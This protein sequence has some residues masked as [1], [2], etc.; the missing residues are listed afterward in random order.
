[1]DI[2]KE[3]LD[4]LNAVLKVKVT[5]NDYKAQVDSALKNYTKKASM[6]G[7]RPGKVPSA[8]VKKM[9]GKSILVDEINKMLN[10]NIHKYIAD[11][12]IEILGNPIP[13]IDSESSIDWDKQS[14]FEFLFDLGLAPQLKIDFSLTD[15][16]PYYNIIVD[17]A[18]IDKYVDDV[19]KRYGKIVPQEVSEADD[20][21]YGDLVELDASNEILAGGIFRTSSIFLERYNKNEASKP[22]IGVKQDEKVIVDI[23]KLADGPADCAAMLGITP[24]AAEKITSKFQFAVKSISRIQ[25][26]EIN[27]ELFEKIYGKDQVKTIDDFRGRIK[28]ELESH[29]GKESERR[30]FTDTVA[31]IKKNVMV[32]LPDEFLKRWIIATNEKPITYEQVSAEYDRYADPLKWQLIEN[33][34][35]KDNEITVTDDEAADYLRNLIRNQYKRYNLNDIEAGELEN[36]A[37]RML[38]NEEESK[39][40]YNQLYGNKVIELLKSKLTLNKKD[41][42]FD[43]FLKLD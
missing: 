11:N 37:K 30:F 12:K 26:A 28:N 22:L 43:D 4:E 13:K 35:I 19:R 29:Y 17:E 25:P 38:A 33:K 31:T 10:D 32:K 36:T 9:Y 39:R 41:I 14:E 23:V 15:S 3:N 21:L 34:I 7:F 6:P 16:V 42:S 5:P 27:E 40:I 8:L 20:M 1:M 18:Q 24:D 2:V